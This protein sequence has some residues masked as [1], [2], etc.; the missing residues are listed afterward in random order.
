MLFAKNISHNFDYP[1]FSNINLEL[2]Q[3]KSI[4]IIGKSGSGKSTLLHI[5]ASLLKPNSGEVKICNTDIYDLTN[6]KL[7]KIR[8]ELIGIIFQTH[9]LFRGFSAKENLDISSLLINKKIDENILK[10]LKINN[11]IKQNISTLSGGQQQRVS[12]ARV[13]IK[14]PKIIFADEPTGNLDKSTANDVM[15]MI[16][17][18]IKEYNSSLFL[19]THDEE[20]ASKCDKIFLLENKELKLL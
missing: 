4:A 9:Y 14:K 5:L 10:E 17:K 20:L 6:D 13:L 18:Y 19:V 15:N 3:Q 11:V 2:Q 7:L 8:R 12:I 1:L 16:F